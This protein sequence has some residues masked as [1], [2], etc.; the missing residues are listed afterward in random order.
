MS[1]VGLLHCSTLQ[2]KCCTCTLRTPSFP[3]LQSINSPLV[4]IVPH[5]GEISAY[6]PFFTTKTEIDAAL[7][8]GK[9]MSDYFGLPMKSEAR[10]YDM[11]EISPN[12]SATVLVSKVAPTEELGGIVQKVG[13]ATQHIVPNRSEW[14]VP[15][16]IGIVETN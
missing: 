10:I 12:S 6:S 16:L 8:E 14:S 3:V 5:G 13:G 7:V 2:G 9:N 1:I 15:R 11:Y 4:K